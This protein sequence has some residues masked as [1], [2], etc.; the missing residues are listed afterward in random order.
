MHKI[1]L[2]DL[3]REGLIKHHLPIGKSS[4]LSDCFRAGVQWVLRNIEE[5]DA[6]NPEDN[7]YNRDWSVE[8][9]LR[10]KLYVVLDTHKI[11]RQENAIQELKEVSIKLIKE[12]NALQAKID[13][14]MLEFCPEE[15]T[16]DQIERWEESQ[17]VSNYSNKDNI[18]L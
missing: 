7:K 4:Q 11:K 6:F 9:K 8:A 3:E 5:Y 16:Q 13:S 2:T 14:L 17:V 15:M 1:E 12:N 10:A 18:C